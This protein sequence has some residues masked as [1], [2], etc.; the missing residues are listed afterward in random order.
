MVSSSRP[1]VSE[2]CNKMQGS[3]QK[4]VLWTSTNVDS[5]E[6]EFPGSDLLIDLSIRKQ[7]KSKSKF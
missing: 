7:N 1:Y 4:N 6:E 2:L 3:E 5:N